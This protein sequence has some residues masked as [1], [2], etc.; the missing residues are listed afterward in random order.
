MLAQ[1]LLLNTEGKPI[2]PQ[3]SFKY[4]S[5][6]VANVHLRDRPSEGGFPLCWD[7]VIQ[8]SR[9]L[10]YVANTHQM[11]IDHG[12]TVLTWYHPFADIDAA[13]TRQQMLK[14]TWS[15]WAQV[16]IDDL[17]LAHP[18]LDVLVTRID[19]KLWGHAMIQPG[20]GFVWSPERIEAT[21]PLGAIHFAGTDLSGM[22]LFEEAFHHGLRAAE[23]SLASLHWQY[24]PLEVTRA[25]SPA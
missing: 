6:M 16:V 8:S 7:N 4:G 1:H 17:S 24:D 2:R 19:I 15:D 3:A 25:E 20:V 18:D 21:R 12:P 13:S 11:G 9:S 22:A 14:L 5:W 23:E 10:G